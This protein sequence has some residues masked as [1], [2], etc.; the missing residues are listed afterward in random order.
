MSTYLVDEAKSVYAEVTESQFTESTEKDISK[1]RGIFLKADLVSYN[2]NYYSEEVVKQFVDQI[3]KQEFLI[4]M[5]T[6]H[7]DS[8]VLDI[9]AKVTKAWYDEKTKEAWFEA[10]F[11]DTD[12]AKQVKKLI[13]QGFVKYVSVLYIAKRIDRREMDGKTVNAILEGELLRID[14]VDR[15]GVP[16]AKITD[17]ERL[18][19]QPKEVRRDDH[20]QE[21]EY[22]A[23]LDAVRKEFE[24]LK[25]KLEETEQKLKEVEEAKAQ[26]ESELETNKKEVESLKEIID[27]LFGHALSQ[28]KAKLLEKYKEYQKSPKIWK[29]IESALEDIELGEE[30]SL[31]VLKAFEENAEQRIGSILDVVKELEEEIR[32]K[33]LE[34]NKPTKEQL[35]KEIKE[36]LQDT[37]DIDKFIDEVLEEAG[38]IPSK[39]QDQE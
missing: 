1:I 22:K 18:L 36:K 25:S 21:Q 10:E 30:K 39:G 32:N 26:L 28:V 27:G 33:M 34:E 20:M 16:V 9:V 35:P 14:F 5:M 11:A 2:N 23:Q 13:Q 37:S 24:E 19:K 4:T 29:Q 15:P 3:N 38:L 31:D 7:W 8:S 6:S 17:Y 12:A